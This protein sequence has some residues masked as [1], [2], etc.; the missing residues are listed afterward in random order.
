MFAMNNT[1]VIPAINIMNLLVR[2][3]NLFCLQQCDLTAWLV[4][5]CNSSKLESRPP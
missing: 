5:T 1:A 4:S 3:L 2:Y